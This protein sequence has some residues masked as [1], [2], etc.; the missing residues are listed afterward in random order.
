MQLN[1]AQILAL[2]P[3][4]SSANAG[5]KLANLKTWKHLGHSAEA[6]WGECQGSAM[7]QVR[8]DMRD[9]TSRCSCPSRKFPCKHSLGLLLLAADSPNLVPP[10]APPPWVSEWL[11]KRESAQAKRQ[12]QA[13]TPVDDAVPTKRRQP[14]ASKTATKRTTLV[15]KGID[16]LD[17]WLSDFVRNGLAG[18]ESKPDS[19]WEEQAARMVDAQAPGIAARIRALAAIPNSGPEWPQELLFAIGRLALLT[20][21]YRRIDE[22]DTPLQE[23]VRLM[24]GWTLKE[25]EVVARGE[26]ID[27]HWI[28]LGER[29]T[30]EGRL[31]ARHTWLMG[32]ATSR[33]A[34]VLQFSHHGSTWNEVWVPGTEQQGTLVYWPSAYGQ[35]ALMHTRLGQ[36]CT[37]NERLPGLET[38]EEHLN[39]VAR[40]LAQQ[41]WPERFPC[42]LRNVVPTY[43]EARWSVQDSAGT[44]LS[45]KPGI[46][47]T[48][49]ALSGGRPIDLACI[50]NGQWLEPLGLMVDGDYHAL[51]EA[52]G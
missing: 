51:P 40:A 47:W 15:A 6:L 23:D 50:W 37:F 44:A 42:V 12:E 24:V 11:G 39:A 38:I 1:V 36:A 20:H 48:L 43:A 22:L 46:H 7:Y 2:A 4:A 21:A 25:E 34:L 8:V 19:F 31:R 27:D 14:S 52:S 17:L 26:A 3:D 18:V 13:N 29:I 5:K 41:P 49:L 33:T 28:V 45:L 35:R 32:A 30:E 9:M 10:S 16:A